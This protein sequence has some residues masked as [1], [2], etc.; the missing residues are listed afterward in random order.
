MIVPKAS[1]RSLALPACTLLFAIAAC[2]GGDTDG[3]GVDGEGGTDDGGAG[4]TGAAAGSSGGNGSG[5]SGGESSTGGQDGSGVGGDTS[6]VCDRGI[7]CS[8]EVE[9]VSCCDQRAVP[10]GSFPM[11]RSASGGDACPEGQACA[12]AET[13]EHDVSVSQFSLDTFE[14][15]VG[16]FRP[17]VDSFDALNISEGEGAH[18]AIEGSGWKASFAGLMPEE[19][20]ALRDSLVSCG[21]NSTWSDTPGNK[22]DWPINCVNWSVAFAFCIWD[23]GRLPTEAEWER[24]AAGGAENRL[25]PWGETAPTAEHASYLSGAALGRVGRFESG[26]GNY[27]HHDLAGNVWEWSLDWLDSGW[28]AGSGATCDDCARVSSGTHRVIRGG[29]H[30]F[31][32]VTLRA[33]TRSGDLPSAAEDFIGFRC[34]R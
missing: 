27:G 20:S 32:A 17:F 21:T 13:P 25:Y 14:V 9:K 12:E 33:A 11:G 6:K 2:S 18:P 5:G 26:V 28:Y 3:N 15:T 29:G 1:L 4:G 19:A 31:A 22:D 34:A 30:S 16:R 24:A 8:P 7:L 23:G 10:S